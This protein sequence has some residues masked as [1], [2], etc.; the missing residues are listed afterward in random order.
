MNA[1]WSALTFL[2]RIPVRFQA[3]EQDWY[4]SVKYYPYVGMVIGI[5]LAGI[6]GITQ[7]LFPDILLSLVVI[8]SWSISLAVCI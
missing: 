2:T 8:A 1:F 3:T 4:Q 7:W 5:F 6:A